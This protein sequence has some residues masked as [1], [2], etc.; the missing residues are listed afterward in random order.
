MTPLYLDTGLILKLLVAE[1]L[2]A[3]V[4][5]FLDQQGRP[6]WYSRVAEIEVE[7]TLHA[8]C[9]RGQLTP[10]DCEDGQAL[11]RNL[12]AEGKLVAPSL[13]LD[14]IADE[15]LRLAPNLTRQTGCRTMDLM[16]LAAARLLRAT[17]FVSTDR[18]QLA[19]AQLAGFK[20]HDLGDES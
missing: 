16:H 17:E 10:A 7:N 12:L 13:T 3:R 4:E 2:S 1:P 14:A 8:M 19:A 18:R 5:S 6:L 11:V 15:L 20:V 9:F